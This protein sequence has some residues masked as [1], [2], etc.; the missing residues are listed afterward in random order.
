VGITKI[1]PI[2]KGD[3]SDHAWNPV[4]LEILISVMQPEDDPVQLAW[5]VHNLRSGHV[6]Y[7]DQTRL[8]GPLHLAKL[9]EEYWIEAAQ[10][11]DLQLDDEV[12]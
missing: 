4:P 2:G 5:A 8:P 12:N 7:D 3:P 10:V 6:Q 11:S 9:A 1:S